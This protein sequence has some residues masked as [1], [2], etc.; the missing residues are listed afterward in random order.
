[1]THRLDP[2]LR[3][4]A[5]AVLGATER[6]RSVGR[7]TITNLQQGGFEGRLYPVN[8]G[9]DTVCGLRC[10]A[11][12]AALPETVDHVIFALS[13]QRVEAALEE[14]IAHGAKAATIMSQLVI[15]DDHEPCLLERVRARVLESGLLLCG[16]NAMGFYNCH[17]G[18]WACG[19]DTRDNHLRGGNVTLI[20][21]SGSGMS[22]IVDC[23]ERIDFNLAVSTGQ[24]LCVGMHD[25]M[26][27]AIEQHAPRVIG[28]F[29]ETVRDPQAM[30]AV[31]EKA[32]QRQIPVVAIKVGRTELSARLA[33]SHSGAMAGTDAA[34]QAL[35]DRY[36]VQRVDDMDEFATALM[37]FAQPHPVAAGAL[38]SIHDS[39]GER[40]LLI[41]LADDMGAPLAT[42]T[43]PTVAK[44]EALLDP[45]LPAVNPLDAW[46]AGG[47]NADRIMQDCLA[48]LMCDPQAAFGAVIHDRAPLSGL[49]HEYIDYMRVA[50][51]ASGKPVF[52]VS[53]RQGSGSDPQAVT[54]TREGFPVIDGLRS[55]LTGVKCLLAYRDFQQRSD[56]RAPVIDEPLIE[57]TKQQLRAAATLDEAAS[58]T[59]LQ[60]L[61]LPVVKNEVIANEAEALQAATRIGYPVVLKTAAGIR[62]KTEQNGVCLD[63]ADP[64]ALTRAYRDMAGRLGPRAMVASMASPHAVEMVLGMVRDHQFGPLVMLGFGGIHVETLHDVAFALPPFDEDTALRLVNNLRQRALLTGQRGRPA[65]AIEAFCA[66]AT[67]FSAVVAALGDALEEVD[68]NPILVSGNACVA[69]DALIIG[70]P[71][72]R[73]NNEQRQSS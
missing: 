39:G 60:K 62:H 5:I 55:F 9:R 11:N 68:I 45:G 71:G 69:V 4:R 72:G 19:F 38:V 18:V 58:L 10:Y 25:Y 49:Y 51:K 73:S 56:Q 21:H 30:M 50:H 33:E 59:M 63:L 24:E 3:P 46:G 57:D 22:G 20:S 34:Y 31:L 67:R 35:F 15:A 17:D 8:P 65:A 29:M 1:M 7:R 2:L 12:L 64:E 42:V 37:M 16:A 28:L 36:G 43:E 26:D 23:E 47:E 44:L 32:R 41:D 66:M 48:A 14:V 61:G 54:V 52:L 6:P 13:D 40:Q 53:N 27:F 70:R